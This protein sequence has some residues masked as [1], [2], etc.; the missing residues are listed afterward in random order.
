MFWTFSLAIHSSGSAFPQ[1]KAYHGPSTWQLTDPPVPRYGTQGFGLERSG[2]PRKKLSSKKLAGFL[3]AMFSV[4]AP[5]DRRDC[6]RLRV[7]PAAS[8][9]PIFQG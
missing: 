1:A 4:A 7:S 2:F 5:L 3:K 6:L 9:R 8:S